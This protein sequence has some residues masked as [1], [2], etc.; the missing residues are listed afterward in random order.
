MNDRIPPGTPENFAWFASW[1][2]EQ[3]NKI[4]I[5]LDS[6]TKEFVTHRDMQRIQEDI[7]RAHTRIRKIEE[8]TIDELEE[9]VRSME[10]SESNEN[11]R[12]TISEKILGVIF[13]LLQFAVTIWVAVN[14]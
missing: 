5:K 6:I 12:F 4:E 9:R 13:V 2:A 10:M 11:A 14:K 3:F 1:I 7:N 8:T